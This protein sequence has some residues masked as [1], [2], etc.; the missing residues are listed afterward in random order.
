MESEQ[1]RYKGIRKDEGKIIKGTLTEA[2]L[3]LKASSIPSKAENVVYSNHHKSA[4]G[5]SQ[6]RFY[7]PAN[8]QTDYTPGPG[9]YNPLS[10]ANRIES[11]KGTGIFASAT[12]ITRFNDKR[13]WNPG[14]GRYDFSLNKSKRTKSTYQ[15]S[16]N[17]SVRQL[18]KEEVRTAGKLPGPADYDERLRRS[19]STY[20]S[21]FKSNVNRFHM[22]NA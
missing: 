9:N 19:A 2:P 18:F 20:N 21:I 12:K 8:L 17:S 10:L 3:K 1:G 16:T 14:P 13:N 4:F 5:N 22:E 6:E 7:T 11:K 15:F